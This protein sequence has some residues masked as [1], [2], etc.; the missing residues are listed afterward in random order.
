MNPAPGPPPDDP[1]ARAAQTKRD[2]TRSA[3]LTAADTLFGSRGWARTRMEDV[4]GAAGVSAATAYNHFPTKHELVAH[5]Y[6]PIVSALRHQADADLAADRPVV[7]ALKDQVRALVRVTS[8]NRVLT[9]A[10]WSAIEEYAAKV[11]ST[12][13]PDDMADPRV[14]APAPAGLIMLIQHGQDTGQLRA[15]PP[16]YDMG[17]VAVNMVLTRA[18]TRPAEPADAVTELLLTVMFGSLKPELLLGAERPFRVG[19]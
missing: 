4:A 6:R 15:Y 2:R 16:A 17:G 11:A 13:D 8:R 12:P 3:L 14:I 9:A 5:V 1:R 10:F 18:V 19:R 7:E